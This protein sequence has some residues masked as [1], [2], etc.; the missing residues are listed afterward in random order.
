MYQLFHLTERDDKGVY[1][2]RLESCADDGIE[3]DHVRLVD[4]VCAGGGGRKVGVCGLWLGLRESDAPG[5]C[6]S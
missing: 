5:T 2:P 6:M 1:V 3:T 4:L